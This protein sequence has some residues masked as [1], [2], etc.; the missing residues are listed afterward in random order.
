MSPDLST[1]TWRKSRHSQANGACVELGSV[2]GIVAVRDSKNPAHP[3][4]VFTPSAA[5]RLARGIK[6]GKHL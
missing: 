2:P 5:A 4:L 6:A 3:A 1:V